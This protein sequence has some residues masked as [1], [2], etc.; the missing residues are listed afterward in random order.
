MGAM[1]AKR[2]IGK[3]PGRHQFTIVHPAIAALTAT[4]LNMI[5]VA[6]EAV[7]VLGVAVA[8]ATA[9][10]GDNTDTKN[11]NLIDAGT[12]SG[13]AEVGNLDLVTGTNLTAKT[14]RAIVDADAGVGAS[15]NLDAGDGL[16]LEVEEV[17]S[18]VAI[19]DLLI[20]IVYTIRA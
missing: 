10:T 7:T 19:P 4:Q 16:A 14:P 20:T 2:N 13:T 15:F 12:G 3:E 17:G 9:V 5:W 8:A 1:D 6:P 18:G 11:L